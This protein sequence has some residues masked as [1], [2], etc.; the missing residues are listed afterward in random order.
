MW[1]IRSWEQIWG[2]YSSGLV[3]ARESISSTAQWAA[4]DISVASTPT[5]QSV[6]VT[7]SPATAQATIV[8]AIEGH[9]ERGGEL[10]CHSKQNP[11]CECRTFYS[12]VYN[13]QA[14]SVIKHVAILLYHSKLFIHLRQLINLFAAT[15]R[16]AH[17]LKFLSLL[18]CLV[19]TPLN[20]LHSFLFNEK[21][22]LFSKSQNKN[23]LNRIHY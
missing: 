18:S 19:R 16:G 4:A 7:T 20:S 9:G 10:V 23:S 6:E 21:Q 15:K 22:N 8:A 14:E 12:Y 1:Q 17:S 13:P 2:Y 5:A 3:E 11:E